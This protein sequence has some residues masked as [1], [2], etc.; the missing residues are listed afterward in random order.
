[1]LSHISLPAPFR[2]A[3]LDSADVCRRW[4][5]RKAEF[6]A[7]QKAPA[8]SVRRIGTKPSPQ[9]QPP[10]PTRDMGVDEATGGGVEGDGRDRGAA[11][12]VGVE[13]LVSLVGE[14]VERWPGPPATMS[15]PLP[16]GVAGPGLPPFPVPFHRGYG[17]RSLVKPAAPNHPYPATLIINSLSRHCRS[18]LIRQ[19]FASLFIDT[20][21]AAPTQPLHGMRTT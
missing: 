17:E 16:P 14:V 4:F 6:L 11:R 21:V 18:A 9:P 1:L 10:A 5:A 13:E 15:G 20:S 19:L 8:A 12:E 2:L 3:A 7:A